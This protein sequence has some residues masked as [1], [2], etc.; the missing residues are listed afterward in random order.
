MQVTHL[1]PVYDLQ[2]LEM[3]DDGLE[4]L[5]LQVRQMLDGS[6]PRAKTIGAIIEDP[7]YHERLL[8]FV[9]RFREDRSS[10]PPVREDGGIR[11]QPSFRLA[12]ATFAELPSFIRYA[13]RLPRSTRALVSHLRRDEEIRPEHCDPE[14]AQR[15][16]FEATA[17][18][19]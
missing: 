8:G 12:E 13:N 11:D 2:L 19:A 5:E 1:N 18:A 9:V 10:A 6:H 17:A 14:V 7:G 4:Q 3:F 16:G 15:F